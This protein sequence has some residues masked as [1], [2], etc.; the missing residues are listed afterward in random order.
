M[1]KIDQIKKMAIKHQFFFNDMKM[2]HVGGTNGKGSV[3][4]MLSHIL[5][6][7]YKVGLYQSP[8]DQNRFDNISINQNQISTKDVDTL[9][10]KYQNDF[11]SFQLSEFE[12]DTWIALAYFYE[13]KVD[14]AIIEVGLGGKDDATNIITPILSII[15]NV[16]YDHTDVL[17][18]DIKEI[19]YHKSGIIKNNVPFLIG[20]DMNLNAVEVI[21]LHATKSSSEVYQSQPLQMIEKNPWI[22]VKYKDL[23]YQINTQATYQMSNIS[24]VLTAIDI[25]RKQGIEISESS[26][27]KGLM[28]PIMTKRFEI[29]V[30]YP[31]IIC[32]AAHNKEGAL[33]LIQTLDDLKIDHPVFIASILKDKPIIEM[34][35]IFS[36]KS[37]QIYLTTF[38][39]H[40]AIDLN[41]VEHPNIIKL[42]DYHDLISI[43]KKEPDKTYILTGSLYFLREVYPL[44]KGEFQ[45]G[46]K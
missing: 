32:D 24:L 41:D 18:K 17:G 36:K 14:Y 37:N 22:H 1:F 5:S 30:N 20:H 46:K 13:Q 8:Y 44:I 23:S 3:T 15:T 45:H 6:D 43:I 38:K 9:L 28:M 35:D 25:L 19:A 11:E 34:L 40:R 42:F 27:V 7:Y 21:R 10:K 29:I 12:I 33:A 39:F 4:S 2:I 31:K 26:I 16:G